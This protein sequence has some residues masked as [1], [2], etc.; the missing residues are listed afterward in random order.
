MYFEK[1]VGGGRHFIEL[2]RRGDGFAIRRR[3]FVARYKGGFVQPQSQQATES[4]L[5]HDGSQNTLSTASDARNSTNTGSTLA[6]PSGSGQY[7]CV[8][9]SS[10]T[11]R[12]VAIASSTS[13]ASVTTAPFYGILQNKPRGGEAA[14]IGIF[15][16]SKVVAGS[17]TIVPGSP[18]MPSTAGGS[19]LNGTV[20]LWATGNP[21]IGFALEGPT[22]AGQVITAMVFN[23]GGAYPSTA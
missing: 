21:K 15:G 14:D 22:A 12:T 7:L 3:G 16:I 4:P 17:T 18:I 2:E 1:E 11:A 5:I 20:N 23:T 9:L 10:A 6:G 13:G 8:V 19:S